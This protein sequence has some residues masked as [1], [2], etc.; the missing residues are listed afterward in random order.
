[1]IQGRPAGGRVET[2]HVGRGVAKPS[3]CC[4]R[5]DRVEM[6]IIEDLD[7]ILDFI[8]EHYVRYVLAPIAIL[9][10]PGDAERVVGYLFA[11][12]EFAHNRGSSRNGIT[13]TP[14]VQQLCAAYLAR[15][16]C[17]QPAYF[18]SRNLRRLYEQR[19]DLT[20][21]MLIAQGFATLHAVAGRHVALLKMPYA[22]R[23]NIALRFFSNMR[24]LW[25]RG[26]HVIAF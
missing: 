20:S 12:T 19:G 7:S 6:P 3:T 14:G 22:V 11:L 1:M 23:R 2:T 16:N 24:D 21:E 10:A 18:S 17:I 5:I 26:T 9:N 4:A 8:R 13:S 25:D 15:F